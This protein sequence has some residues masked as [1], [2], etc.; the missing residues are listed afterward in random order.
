MENIKI[1]QTGMPQDPL[2]VIHIIKV[3]LGP[4]GGNDYEFSEL[5]RIGREF[6]QGKIT[7]EDAITAAYAIKSAKDA[8]DYH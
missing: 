3:A 7:R 1:E 2:A 8:Y 5:D 4:M 6:S